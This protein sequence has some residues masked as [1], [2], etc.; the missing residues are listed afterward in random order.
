ML[1]SLYFCVCIS[2]KENDLF[3]FFGAD[4]NPVLTWAKPDNLQCSPGDS[5][6]LW[7]AEGQCWVTLGQG[8]SWASVTLHR[9]TSYL[10]H[11]CVKMLHCSCDYCEFNLRHTRW[12]KQT[13]IYT[14]YP[15]K[16]KE[17]SGFVCSFFM[18]I[19][20][21][22]WWYFPF[23]WDDLEGNCHIS[24]GLTICDWWTP[25]CSKWLLLIILIM[26]LIGL[27]IGNQTWKTFKDC[28]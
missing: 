5:F 27:I 25:C 15:P 12:E 19:F 23:F 21:C 9:S 26:L 4:I 11:L 28:P 24:Y 18:V 13:E 14:V 7:R 2:W 20:K 8:F 1:H 6:S 10:F 16:K 3:F 22:S 17:E